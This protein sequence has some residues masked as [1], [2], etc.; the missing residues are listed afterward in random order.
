[1]YT[2]LKALIRL[3]CRWPIRHMIWLANT[4]RASEEVGFGTECEWWGAGCARSIVHDQ[5]HV[6]FPSRG[7]GCV[8][9]GCRLGLA[10]TT[11]QRQREGTCGA[12]LHCPPGSSPSHFGSKA[13]SA[14]NSSHIQ[15][16][17]HWVGTVGSFPC[18]CRQLL[19]GQS[20]NDAHVAEQ[21]HCHM[22][23]LGA[24][25]E[26]LWEC[27]LEPRKFPESP[28]LLNSLALGDAPGLMQALGDPC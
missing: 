7:P 18:G 21:L 9:S 27:K 22:G 26:G 17:S 13:I 1:M 14:C 19:S 24:A 8:S 3:P 23:G 15:S 25:A 20:H 10:S 6:C 2:E 12:V 28:F 4:E 16:F 5:G 11:W